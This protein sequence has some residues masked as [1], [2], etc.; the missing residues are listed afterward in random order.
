[1]ESASAQAEKRQP[2]KVG[3]DFTRTASFAAFGLFLEG[4]LM[5][6]WMVKQ[7]PKLA[8]MNFTTTETKLKSLAFKILVECALFS[9]LYNTVIVLGIS[10]IKGGTWQ[11]MKSEWHQKF[12]TL[13]ATDYKFWPAIQFV[14]Y[15]WVPVHYQTSVCYCGGIVWDMLV[16]YT[17]CTKDFGDKKPAIGE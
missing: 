7:Q 5:Y 10:G 4:P 16:S 17:M 9:P 6:T 15:G 14:N 1:M 11:E 12:L 3:H 13:Q 8:P 2:K